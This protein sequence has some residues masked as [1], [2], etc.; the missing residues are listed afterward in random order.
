M[1][2]I[3]LGDKN[4]QFFH[5]MATITHK[6]NHIISLTDSN[7]NAVTDHEQKANLLWTAFRERMGVSEY[8][9]IAY[10]LAELLTTQNL[11]SLGDDFSQIEIEQTIK[12]LP[13]NHAPGPD[14]F[15]G[16]FVKKY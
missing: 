5:S 12:S 9:G 6:R 14:G 8:N 16:L 3:N 7:G 13:N 10:N 15:N 1:R 4:T 11:D 2:W